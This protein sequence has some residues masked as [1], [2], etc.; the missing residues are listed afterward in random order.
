MG[1]DAI[2]TRQL[3]IPDAAVRDRES[4]EMLRV[5]IA[6]QG[7]HC[8]LKVGMYQETKDVSE[9]KA[10]GIILADAAKHIANA[11]QSAYSI[12]RTASLKAI[13]D[14]FVEELASPTSEA[15]GGFA[16]KH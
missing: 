8:S 6:E 13:R 11:L 10:W 2:E 4:V 3:F 5:W 16:Q 9:T 7:L 15:K 12:D 1:H 14:S